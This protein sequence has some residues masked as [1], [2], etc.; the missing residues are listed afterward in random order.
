M[1]SIYMTMAAVSA[2]AVAAPATAQSGGMKP[3]NMEYSRGMDHSR[4]MEQSGHMG[5]SWNGDRAS[6]SDLQAQFDAGMASGA[7]S[8]GEAMRLRPRLR[9]LAQME[10]RYSRAGF[11]TWE[12]ND[13]RQ[14]SRA[15][16]ASIRTAERSGR[17]RMD[18]DQRD[19]DGGKD[20][21]SGN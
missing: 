12:R 4:G 8:S 11:N 6:T 10:Q 3:G 9:Q 17:G 2:L 20:R 14:R 15:L 21:M 19:H 13:L 5:M 16:S 7:I 18:R 1:K